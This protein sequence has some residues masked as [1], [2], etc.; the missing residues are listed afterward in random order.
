MPSRRPVDTA[1]FTWMLCLCLIWGGNYVA[2]KLAAPGMSLVLQAS[3]RSAIAVVLLLVWARAKTIPLFNIDRTLWPGLLAGA[4]FAAEFLFLFAGL[5]H[6]GASR[7]AIFVYLAPCF[8]AL[9]L[10]WLVPSER[11]KAGQWMGIALALFGVIVAFADGFLADRSSLLG[12]LYGVLAGAFWGATTVVI[13]VSALARASAT[14]TLFYQLGLSAL[15]LW[16]ASLLMGEHGIV[17]LS[18]VVIASLLYQGVIVAFASY[19]AWF[20]LLTRY[21]AARLSVF[22]FLTP[23][24]SVLAGAVVLNEPLRP[25][26]L[27]SV[28]LVGAGLYWVNRA[29]Y[30]RKVTASE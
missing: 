7:M 22:I 5:A 15:I 2:A 29:G 9:G 19:L 17:S 3:V 30:S 10:Q 20:W 1:G 8:T 6:T 16:P 26:F 21:L 4:L 27:A 14:K 25:T 11:L 24:F 18:P 23:I 28:A 13:R 12:D